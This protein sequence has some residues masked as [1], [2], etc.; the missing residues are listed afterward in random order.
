M[1]SPRDA[2]AEQ[3]GDSS[4]SAQNE[5]GSGND[6]LSL[7]CYNDAVLVAIIGL[8]LI[9]GSIGLALRRGGRSRWEIVGYS[10]RRETITNALSLGAI[11]RGEANV[12]GGIEEAELVIIATPVL[13]IKEI[14]SEIAPHLPSGCVVTDT[15]STKVQV[16]EWAKEI[17]PPTVDFIGGHPMAGR[18]A[19]GIQAA[20]AE[21]FRRRTYC[22]TPSEKASQ[23]SIDTVI[24]MVKKLG[25]TPLFIDAQE[26]DSLVAGISHLPM[27]LS[28]AL[29]SLTAANPSWSKMSRLTASAYH[30][31]TRLA[32]GNPEVN[33][34]ICLSNQGPITDWI[35]KFS[36][37]LERYR[38]LVGQGDKHLEQALTEANKARQEWLKQTR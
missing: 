5:R 29:V 3:M 33:S 2:Y 18:E 24:D 27:L 10:R 32:S 11:D 25:A 23:K 30:D 21:L 15:G 36:Q 12:G 37:E 13:T 16:T 19:Y 35:D 1:T 8:G 17:L 38:Q 9:G 7:R 28:A 31:F 14:F 26:H 20:E 22:L 4:S 34:H 6:S